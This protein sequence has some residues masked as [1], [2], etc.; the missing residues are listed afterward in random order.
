MSASADTR[1][2]R[3][4][5]E[6]NE[7]SYRYYVLNAPTIPD[8]D[9][10]RLL[11]ELIEL[12]AKHPDLIRPDSPAQRIGSDLTKSFST[13]VHDIPMLSLENTYSEEEF[14]EFEVRVRRELPDEPLHYV[15]EL[16]IDGVALSLKYENGLL[17][18]G[19]TRGDGIQGK[20][21]RRM[22][23]RSGSSPSG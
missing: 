22:Y 8:Q 5:R 4:I 10:D 12:E 15:A 16:K 18:R 1:I 6:L 13:L 3:L 9:Y 11:R 19:V 7:H 17:V 20:T 23:A 21:S 14:R 2:D